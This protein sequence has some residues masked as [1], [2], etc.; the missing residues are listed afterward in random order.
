MIGGFRKG[1]GLGL[2]LLGVLALVAG[3]GAAIA[4]VVELEK[5]RDGGSNG[6]GREGLLPFPSGQSDTPYRSSSN[7]AEEWFLG[8]AALAAFGVVSLV[9]GILLMVWGNR[10]Q[11]KHLAARLETLER[12]GPPRA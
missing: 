6:G 10:A 8:S 4:G 2:L 12:A 9:T 7:N 1:F 5:G 11:G 3:V